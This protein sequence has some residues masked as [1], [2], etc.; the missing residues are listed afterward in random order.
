MDLETLARAW[1]ALDGL[2]RTGL[3][4]A[5]VLFFWSLYPAFVKRDEPVAGGGAVQME[6]P[7][8]INNGAMQIGGQ[9]NVQQNTFVNAPARY[10][11]KVEV[12]YG[13]GDGAHHALVRFRVT[14]NR[15]WSA[16]TRSALEVRLNGPWEAWE[17]E[18]QPFGWPLFGVQ[19]SENRAEGWLAYSVA[20]AP[21]GA[22]VVMRFTSSRPVQ[23]VEVRAEPAE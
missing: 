20:N 21:V 12:A 8:I 5:F 17:F 16:G 4:A 7:V 18:G 11:R 14:P 23:V 2:H 1:S 22:D 6:K 3:V 9:G 10:E 19:Q 13:T 15:P